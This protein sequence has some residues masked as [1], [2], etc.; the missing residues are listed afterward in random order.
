M[1]TFALGL[2]NAEKIINKH[3]AMESAGNTNLF[4]GWRSLDLI[5]ILMK[6]GI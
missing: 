3:A 5:I 2:L 6:I 1:D 4:T